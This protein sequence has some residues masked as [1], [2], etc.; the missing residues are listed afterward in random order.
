M[1][2]G[3]IGSVTIQKCPMI[4]PTHPPASPQTIELPA[5]HKKTEECR[6]FPCPVILEQ[7]T[8]ITVRDGTRLRADIY[9]PKTE[10]KVPAIIMWGPY[11]KSG[12][13]Q[14]KYH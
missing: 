1:A 5:G 14:F 9:R 12:N 4:N 8:I 2:S 10:E 6:P 7:D 11:G 13:G 3:K